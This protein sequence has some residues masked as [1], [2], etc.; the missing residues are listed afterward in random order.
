VSFVLHGHGK[1][2]VAP[3]LPKVTQHARGRVTV[4]TGA[5]VLVKG[6]DGALVTRRVWRRTPDGLVDAG[7]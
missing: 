1:V 3:R 4:L 6:P 7:S 5:V 2:T